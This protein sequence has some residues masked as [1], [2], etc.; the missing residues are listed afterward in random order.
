MMGLTRRLSRGGAV[1]MRLAFL[2]DQPHQRCGALGRAGWTTLGSH[3]LGGERM[4]ALWDAEAFASM[5]QL[6][7]ALV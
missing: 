2:V 6:F 7:A 4:R 3:R 5:R 1:V